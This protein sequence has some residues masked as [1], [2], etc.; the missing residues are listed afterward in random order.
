M[1]KVCFLT[2]LVI[3]LAATATNTY[4][5]V[6]TAP[7]DW[8]GTYL[9]VCESQNV[10]FNGNASEANLDAKSGPAVLQDITITNSTI[11]GTAAIDSAV[12]T[13][14]AT[15]DTNWPWSI[16][17]HSGYYIGH[18]DSVVADNGL[19]V[20]TEVKKK[21]K[22]QLAIENGNLI[23]TPRYEVGV[24]FNLQ[25]N[26]KSDQMRF[27]YF[28]PQDKVAVQLYKLVTDPTALSETASPSTT[29]RKVIQN[30]RMLIQR[31]G[32]SYTA[33]GVRL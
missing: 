10:V 30:G 4:T 17:S 15:D 27:R 21:C 19:S 3:T 16:Q 28:L 13:I 11:T 12:F 29:V 18:K 7:T 24:E 32:D 1:K 23:A 5:K 20:E 2:A 26:K 6:T 33:I 31:N 25:Y 22:H 14:A 9:I 8:T